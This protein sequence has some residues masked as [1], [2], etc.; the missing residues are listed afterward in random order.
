[1]LL[2]SAIHIISAAVVI[3][4][5]DFYSKSAGRRDSPPQE[6]WDTVSAS[7]PGSL[8]LVCY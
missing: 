6:P 7:S 5:L 2:L 3:E 4:K 1:M 8:P